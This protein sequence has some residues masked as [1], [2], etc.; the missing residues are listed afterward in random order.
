[1]SARSARTGVTSRRPHA[2]PPSRRDVRG[3]CRM[4]HKLRRRPSA[5]PDPSLPV[6]RIQASLTLGS[7]TLLPQAGEGR[8]L[9]AREM[10][11]YGSHARGGGG[12]LS[13]SPGAMSTSDLDLGQHAAPVAFPVLLAGRQHGVPRH[14]QSIDAMAAE[15][16]IRIIGDG[17]GQDPCQGAAK[18]RGSP[19]DRGRKPCSFY[20]LKSS[21]LE[22]RYRTVKGSMVAPGRAWK[23]AGP[24]PGYGRRRASRGLRRRFAPT[25]ASIPAVKQAPSPSASTPRSVLDPEVLSR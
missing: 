11:E 9:P 2:K 6:Y 1:M 24:A 14:E 8:N 10:C 21:T 4:S 16:P 23:V 19:L 7:F 13:C 22:V 20:N 25:A 18:H 12:P 17:T 3:P 5:P 15:E